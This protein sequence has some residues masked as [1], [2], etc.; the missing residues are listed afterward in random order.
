MTNFIMGVP[1]K[2]GSVVSIYIDTDTGSYNSDGNKTYSFVVYRIADRVFKNQMQQSY[3]LFCASQGFLLNQTKR[4]QKT[5]DNIKPEDAMSNIVSE[6]LN[7]SLE[8]IPSDNNYHI[9]IPNWSPFTACNY[10]S[11]V[12]IKNNAS[13]YIFWMQDTDMYCLKTLEYIY[14]SDPSG[15]SFSM[16]P[17]NVRNETGDFLF[18]YSTKIS[19]YTFEHFD[20][21]SNLSAGYYQN[22]TLS[23][24]MVNKEMGEKNFKF[25]R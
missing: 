16:S 3:R 24:D 12:A 8:S 11:K 4:V 19:K 6:F 23:Y 2:P 18:D 13:D 21:L 20:G 10:I 14:T 1:I 17:S 7:G 22:K 25:R 5:Y 9:V 15:I